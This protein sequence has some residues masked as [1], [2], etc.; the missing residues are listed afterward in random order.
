MINQ[1]NDDVPVALWWGGTAIIA[2]AL[3]M[4]AAELEHACDEDPDGVERGD[5]LPETPKEDGSQSGSPYG[6]V[7]DRLIPV[8]GTKG[9]HGGIMR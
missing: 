6:P 3:T 7:M 8:Y 2:V 1:H 5:Q 9:L 4:G